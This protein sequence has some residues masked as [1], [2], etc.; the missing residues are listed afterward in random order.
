MSEVKHD[1][2]RLMVRRSGEHVRIYTR[3]GVDWTERFPRIVEGF[4]KLK[5]SSILLDGEGVI[6][7]D[8]GLTVFDRLHS[9]AHDRDVILFA[10]DLLEL[11]GEDC[12]RELLLKRKLRLRTILKRMQSGV[13]YTDHLETDGATMFEH[14]CRFGCEGIVAKRTDQPYRSGR[15]KSWLKIKNPKSPAALRIEG[16]DILGRAPTEA[17]TRPPDDG[18]DTRRGRELSGLRPE[19]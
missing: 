7:D 10:F 9:K 2:Y 13:Y 5:V 11:D 8:R 18:L 17:P 4:R 3:R 6:S 16:G 15:S 14:A 1:G 19:G 12:R